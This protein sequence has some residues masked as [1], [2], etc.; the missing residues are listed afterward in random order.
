VIVRVYPT[1][2]IQ[3]RGGPDWIDSERWDIIAK[4]DGTD[5]EIQP[6]QRK[7]IVQTLLEDRFNLRFHVENR[8]M[9]ILALVVG[10]D[11]PK[12]QPAKEGEIPGAFPGDKPGSLKLQSNPI[13]GL[14][15]YLSNILRTPIIDG[16]G[17]TGSYDITFDPMRYLTPSDGSPQRR[18]DS[19]DRDQAYITEVQ[20]EL[21][22]KLEK[23]KAALAITI[24]DRAERPSEN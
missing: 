10:K 5:G 19:T 16:T 11:G 24:I 4:A 7:E 6:D 17:I 20:E 8:E 21:G 3:M 2:R 13:G 12:L 14:V 18:I 9:D 15:N 22:L 23:R 1:R